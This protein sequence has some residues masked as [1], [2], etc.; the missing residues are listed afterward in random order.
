MVE[1]AVSPSAIA[2]EAIERRATSAAQSPAIL[3]V[4]QV[5]GRPNIWVGD[6]MGLRRWRPIMDRVDA[7]V[8]LGNK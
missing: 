3:R 6:E 7:V 5:T 4:T 1:T 8:S 2:L